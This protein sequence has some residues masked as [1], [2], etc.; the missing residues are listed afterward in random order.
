VTAVGGFV[1]PGDFVDILLTRGRGDGL[2]TDTIL[3]NIRVIAVDQR[4][5]ENNDSPALAATVTVEVT[6]DQGQSL[7]LGQ[8][9][10]TLSLALRD[11]ESVDSAPI[12]RL[13][14]RDLVPDEP[15][16]EVETAEAPK[17]RPTVVIRRGTEAQE[18]T[19]R[20]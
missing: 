13:T 6:A 16:A 20:N 5:D 11:P 8:R 2:V 10:G 4:A 14:L 3:R 7:A 15:V 1:T 12:E 17:R 18:V 19:L 9:A